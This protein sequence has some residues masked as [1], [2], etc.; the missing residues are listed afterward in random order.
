MAKRAPCLADIDLGRKLKDKAAY[1]KRLKAV[2]VQLLCIQQAYLQQG[3]RAVIALEGWDA[4]GKGATIRRLTEKLDPRVVKV[5]PIARPADHEAGRHWLYRFWLRLPEPGTIAVFDRSWYGRV[6]VERVEGLVAKA[7]WQRAYR[8]INDF[9]RLLA[10]DGARLVKL[11]LHVSPEEQLRRFAER[12]AVPYKRWKIG[13]EDFRNVARRADYARAIDDM[14]ART[15]TRH[16]PWHPVPAEH[17]WYGRIA[18]LE[19]VAA[20]LGEGVDLRPKALDAETERLARRMLGRLP[21]RRE[22]S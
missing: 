15:H 11:F 3:R 7:A 17:K 16:A 5:W 12:I 20:R 18:A 8:E 14:L 9:E 4:A 21:K 1:E 19:T 2:Q 10:E 22:T 13:P 6:L